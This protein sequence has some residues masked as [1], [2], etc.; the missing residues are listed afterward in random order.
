M[1]LEAIRSVTVMQVFRSRTPLKVVAARVAGVE[2]PNNKHTEYAI[3]YI[4]GIGPTRAKEIVTATVKL[5]TSQTITQ[6]L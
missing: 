6:T 4:Y 2:I 1:I 5:S 3:R